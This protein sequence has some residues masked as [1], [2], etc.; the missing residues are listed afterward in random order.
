MF[1]VAAK[2]RHFSS[3]SKCENLALRGASLAETLL[4]EG[5]AEFYI[6][7]FILVQLFNS[8]YFNRL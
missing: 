7:K 3:V 2:K 6:S 1:L 5:I 4:L 8:R